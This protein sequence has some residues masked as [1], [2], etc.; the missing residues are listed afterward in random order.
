MPRRCSTDPLGK[1]IPATVQHCA[2]RQVSTPWHCVAYFCTTNTSSPRRR[3]RGN[4]RMGASAFS[5]TMQ[6]YTVTSGQQE[7]SS[8][9]PSALCGHPRHC[10]TTPGTVTTF[11]T[12]LKRTGTGRRH[13]CHCA[14]YGLP[15]TTPSSRPVG[16]G[17]TANLYATTLEVAP[18][19]AQDSP[20]HPNRSE[21]R[22]D[23]H[24]L[25]G[26]VRHASTPRR[27]SVANL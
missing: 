27:N 24:L 9:S 23:S 4:P 3:G 21:I 11:P 2:N 1:T 20:R 6:D 18:I 13:T 14:S 7:R 26:T 22:Q 12:L 25:H 5:M 19:W 17:R 16:G 15:L 8:P 10:S